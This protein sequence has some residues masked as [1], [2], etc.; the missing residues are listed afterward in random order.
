[1]QFADEQLKKID[2]LVEWVLLL[3]DE[4]GFTNR[5]KIWHYLRKEG[6]PGYLLLEAFK[7]TGLFNG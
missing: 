2:D 7:R 4:E 1:M 6:T 3:K 5:L